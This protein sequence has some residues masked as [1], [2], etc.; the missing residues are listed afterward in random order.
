MKCGESSGFQR[1]WQ[2]SGG[3]VGGSES[4]NREEQDVSAFALHS[5]INA[6]FSSQASPPERS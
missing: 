5:H 6:S 3:G 1:A 4:S 2:E